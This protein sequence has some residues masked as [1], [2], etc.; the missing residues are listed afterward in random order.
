MAI[1]RVPTRT[2][3]RS[4]RYR[5]GGIRLHD[6]RGGYYAGMT[7]ANDSQ[8]SAERTDPTKLGETV[9]QHDRPGDV[10]PPDE[11]LGVEDP[12]I[13]GDGTVA[14]DDVESRSVREEPE[15]SEQSVPDADGDELGHDLLDPSDDADRLDDEEQLVAARG[16]DADSTAEVAAVHDVPEEKLR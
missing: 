3:I 11:P 10:Y 5:G 7:D 14:T 1:S 16:D 6:E 12:S 8:S 9:G 13:L 15:L 2:S 4:G